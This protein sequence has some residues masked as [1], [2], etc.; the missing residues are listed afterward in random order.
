MAE[1]LMTVAQVAERLQIG[2]TKAYQL[3]QSGALMGI[4]IG[5]GWRVSETHLQYYLMDQVLRSDQVAD[6]STV[7]YRWEASFDGGKS[8]LHKSLHQ[9]TL[10]EIYKDIEECDA[11]R[12]DVR[13]RIWEV[14]KVII[15][16]S[17]DTEQ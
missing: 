6:G 16:T 1:Q 4:K 9:P 14:T 17:E 3:L 15:A 7:T 12:E 2:Q 8:W 5:N 13:W 11:Q 10:E